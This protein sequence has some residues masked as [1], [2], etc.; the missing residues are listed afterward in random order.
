MTDK[1]VVKK[2][3]FDLS[4]SSSEEDR[5]TLSKRIKESRISYLSMTKD[6]ILDKLQKLKEKFFGYKNN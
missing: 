3:K 1:K 2:V 6:M 5:V 4:D